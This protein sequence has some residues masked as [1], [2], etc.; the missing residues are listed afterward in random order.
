VID[1]STDLR[2]FRR[3]L[4]LSDMYWASR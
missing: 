4:A 3:E 2:A 1:G